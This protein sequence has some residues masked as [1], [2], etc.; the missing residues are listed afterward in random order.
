M[1]AV[2]FARSRVIALIKDLSPEQLATR[3]QGFRNSLSSLVVRCAGAKASF[4]AMITGQPVAPDLRSEL[5]L[6]QPSSPLYQPE[7]ETVTTLE[8]KWEKAHAVLRS[9]LAAVKGDSFD[10]SVVRPGGGHSFTLRWLMTLITFHTPDH[11]GQM[12]MIKQH[13]G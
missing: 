13:L 12:V 9:A 8:A 6:D 5:Y 3:P 4:A 2:E 1:A 11:F 7:G 10:R